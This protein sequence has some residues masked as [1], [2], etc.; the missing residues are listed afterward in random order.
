MTWTPWQFIMTAL[1]GWMN[2]QQQDVIEF[3]RTENQVL[4]EALGHKPKLN[5]AQRRRLAAAAIKLGRNLLAQFGTLFS[6]DTLLGWHRKLI[7]AKYN[8]A[9]KRG[10]RGPEAKKANSIR[11]LVLEM[12]KENLSWGYGHIYGELKKLG[13]KVHWQTVRRVMLDHG[14]LPD[15]D[16]PYKTSWKTFIKSHWECIAAADFFTG[17]TC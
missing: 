4:R 10:K 17:A 1:A 12:C 9:G 2:R 7:A 14:I 5:D 6:P 13:F 11:K 15:P 16:R 8:G 3:L